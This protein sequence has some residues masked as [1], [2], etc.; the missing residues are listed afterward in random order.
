MTMCKCCKKRTADIKVVL[1]DEGT[2]DVVEVVP[3]CYGC[4]AK[5]F[6]E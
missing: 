3:V 6:M 4:Y 1:T 2:G 5:R